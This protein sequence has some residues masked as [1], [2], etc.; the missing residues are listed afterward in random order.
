MEKINSGGLIPPKTRKEFEHN[1]SLVYE[2][3]FRKVSSGD[4]GLIQNVRWATLPHLKKVKLLPNGRINLLT[5]NEHIRLQAN[6]LHN[7]QFM[8]NPNINDIK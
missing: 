4:V 2:D 5:I 7:M 1:M 8:P 6:M 3:T